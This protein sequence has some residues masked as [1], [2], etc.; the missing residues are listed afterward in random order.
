M[1]DTL[2]D[3][4]SGLPLSVSRRTTRL[5]KAISPYGVYG[6]GEII[7]AVFEEGVKLASGFEARVVW[8]P[9]LNRWYWTYN[10]PKVK[11]LTPAFEILSTNY[12]QEKFLVSIK[13]PEFNSVK[14]DREVMFFHTEGV[15]WHTIFDETIEEFLY[16][17]R[18]VWGGTGAAS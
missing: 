2:I 4:S 16:D 11:V 1:S 10:D 13:S 7:A 8:V 6:V 14:Q 3:I 17:C 9:D 18:D 5:R 12:S 15:G